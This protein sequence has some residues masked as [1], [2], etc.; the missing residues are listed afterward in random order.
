MNVS[1]SEVKQGSA[2]PENDVTALQSRSGGGTDGMLALP[3]SNPLSKNVSADSEVSTSRNRAHEIGDNLESA[4]DTSDSFAAELTPLVQRGIE[5]AIKTS[6]KSLVMTLG[7]TGA[8]KSTLINFLNDVMQEVCTV[9]GVPS[10]RVAEHQPNAAPL[11]NGKVSM[12]KFFDVRTRIP[13]KIDR[14]EQNEPLHLVDTQGLQDSAGSKYNIVNCITLKEVTK[15]CSS[16]RLLLTLS[17]H[18]ITTDVSK[19]LRMFCSDIMGILGKPHNIATKSLILIVTQ[20]P[21]GVTLS[22]V[23]E[24]LRKFYEERKKEEAR[25]KMESD[26]SDFVDLVLLTLIEDEQAFTFSNQLVAST[27]EGPIGSGSAGLR[28]KIRKVKAEATPSK[29]LDITFPEES[30]DILRKYARTVQDRAFALLEDRDCIQVPAIMKCLKDLHDL[31][32]L[33][34]RCT[35]NTSFIDDIANDVRERLRGLQEM[36]FEVLKSQ[37]EKHT[38]S[39]QH[40]KPEVALSLTDYADFV[41]AID[42]AAS[43]DANTSGKPTLFSLVQ[44]CCGQEIKNIEEAFKIGKGGLAPKACIGITQSIDNIEILEAASKCYIDIDDIDA[45]S[46]LRPY[47]KAVKFILNFEKDLDTRFQDFVTSLSEGKRVDVSEVAVL[48]N[49]RHEL[50]DVV[51]K[52]EELKSER[53][54]TQYSHY[55]D[56]VVKVLETYCTDPAL[57]WLKKYDPLVDEAALSHV[58]E[59]YEVPV[60]H[61]NELAEDDA[62][63][64]QD[65][66]Y[67]PM[68]NTG[69]PAYKGSHSEYAQR[70][71]QKRIRSTGE[72][73][74]PSSPIDSNDGVSIEAGLSKSTGRCDLKRA[75]R[76][77]HDDHPSAPADSRDV[78][79]IN[80]GSSGSSERHDHKRARMATDKDVRLSIMN[81]GNDL[82]VKARFFESAGRRDLKRGRTAAYQDDNAPDLTDGEGSLSIGARFSGFADLSD[83]R[84]ID[85]NQDEVD[86][87]SSS[88]RVLRA[89][90]TTDDCMIHFRTETYDNSP[91]QLLTE[92]HSR[93]TSLFKRLDAIPNKFLTEGA[94]RLIVAVSTIS[95]STELHVGA[96]AKLDDLRR[97][98]EV[99]EELVNNFLGS[100][101]SQYDDAKHMIHRLNHLRSIQ[102]LDDLNED[103]KVREAVK[104][105]EITAGQK[106]DEIAETLEGGKSFASLIEQMELLSRFRDLGKRPKE[107]YNKVSAR[108]TEQIPLLVTEAEAALNKLHTN[109]DSQCELKE[110]TSTW[111]I[112]EDRLSGLHELL[113]RGETSFGDAT[114]FA[115]LEPLRDSLVEEVK[116]LQADIVESLETPIDELENAGDQLK[117]CYQVLCAIFNVK[118]I[119]AMQGVI[120]FPQGTSASTYPRLENLLDTSALPD[121]AVTALQERCNEIDD[122]VTS[123]GTI[124]AIN[125][126]K[127][128]LNVLSKPLDKF[129]GEQLVESLFVPLRSKSNATLHELKRKAAALGDKNLDEGL[130]CIARLISGEPLKVQIK[131][132]K[133]MKR[134]NEINLASY[135]DQVSLLAEVISDLAGYIKRLWDGQEPADI[136]DINIIQC[137]LQVL[138]MLSAPKGLSDQ[139]K[140]SLIDEH[141]VNVVEVSKESQDYQ[142]NEV[143]PAW[144]QFVKTEIQ[145]QNYMRVAEELDLLCTILKGTGYGAIATKTCIFETLV[146]RV[147]VEQHVNADKDDYEDCAPATPA[148]GRGIV[149]T[150][151]GIFGQMVDTKLCKLHDI[152][153]GPLNDQESA[154][155]F[156]KGTKTL[157]NAFQGMIAAADKGKGRSS[158][159]W[160]PELTRLRTTTKDALQ[161]ACCALM[162]HVE[163]LS[164]FENNH[165]IAMALHDVGNFLYEVLKDYSGEDRDDLMK[166][167]PCYSEWKKV[168]GRFEAANKLRND[169]LKGTLEWNKEHDYGAYMK[170]VKEERDKVI[171]DFVAVEGLLKEHAVPVAEL[172]LAREHLEHLPEEVHDAIKSRS[173]RSPED[174]L[175][176]M[177]DKVFEEFKDA[178]K[179]FCHKL[180]SNPKEAAVIAEKLILLSSYTGIR[181][182]D[183]VLQTVEVLRD[184]MTIS[185]DHIKGLSQQLGEVAALQQSGA[186]LDSL[187]NV[188]KWTRTLMSSQGVVESS[189]K[190]VEALK[191]DDLSQADL[192]I[193][194]GKREQANAE[195]SALVA[196]HDEQ[197]KKIAE[198]KNTRDELKAAVS[199][200][201]G[202]GKE[203]EDCVAECARVHSRAEEDSKKYE[204]DCI[205]KGGKMT[206]ARSRLNLLENKKKATATA[207]SE[208]KEA[209][210]ALAQ[211]QQKVGSP[212][213]LEKITAQ[214]K[215]AK[216][217]L[218]KCATAVAESKKVAA[219]YRKDPA[220]KLH[221]ATVVLRSGET[222]A[223]QEAVARYVRAI[224]SEL[225]VL[226]ESKRDR[227]LELLGRIFAEDTLADL[228]ELSNCVDSTDLRVTVSKSLEMASKKLDEVQRAFRDALSI[229]DFDSVRSCLVTLEALRTIKQPPIVDSCKQQ[230]DEYIKKCRN[231]A[232]LRLDSFKVGDE[233]PRDTSEAVAERLAIMSQ[234]AQC[235]GGTAKIV[236]DAINAVLD[237]ALDV[238]KKPGSHKRPTLKEL[239]ACL[240]S[241]AN[242]AGRL[243]AEHNMFIGMRNVGWNEKTGEFGA[244][245]AVEECMGSCGELADDVDKDS[246][247]KVIEETMKKHAK[248]VEDNLTRPITAS[249]SLPDRLRKLAEKAKAKVPQLEKPRKNTSV[250][251]W[252]AAMWRQI[253]HGQGGNEKSSREEWIKKV[254]K[255]LPEIVAMIF[256]VWTIEK[257]ATAWELCGKDEDA[258]LAPKASQLLGIFRLF[259]LGSKVSGCMDSHLAQ[260]RTGEGKSVTLGVLATINA[261]LGYDV[262]VVCYSQ[263]LSRRDYDG[264]KDIFEIFNTSAQ[265]KYCTLEELI[266]R[267][268]DP[269]RHRR[270]FATAACKRGTPPVLV[271]NADLAHRRPRLLQI[272]EFDQVISPKVYGQDYRYGT[273]IS[274]TRVAELMRHIYAENLGPGNWGE[275]KAS[276]VYKQLEVE[277]EPRVLIGAARNMLQCR[278]A[279]DSHTR[280]SPTGYIVQNGKIG[281]V[282]HDGISF[283]IR[284]GYNTAFSYLREAAAGEVAPETA[285]AELFIP[286]QCGEFSYADILCGQYLRIFGVS[287]TLPARED[288]RKIVEA[289]LGIIRRTLVP[290]IF[291]K[292][293]LTFRDEAD[294][295]VEED[296]SNWRLQIPKHT[297]A[298]M[299]S[300]GGYRAVIVVFTSTSS[301]HAFQDSSPGRD[302]E[303]QS[304]VRVQSITEETSRAERTRRIL[305]ASTQGTITYITRALGRG[306]DFLCRDEKVLDNGGVHVLQLFWSIDSAERIQIQGRTARQGQVG[307]YSLLLC[308][309]HLQRLGFEP[310]DIAAWKGAGSVFRGLEN[311]STVLCAE[312]NAPRVLAAEQSKKRQVETDEAYMNAAR[313]NDKFIEFLASRNPAPARLGAPKIILGLD[314]TSS[315][316]KVI[317]QTKATIGEMLG[318]TEKVLAKAGVTGADFQIQIAVYR[319]Y[320]A[321]LPNELLQL[322]S[323]EMSPAPLVAFLDSVDASY[324]WGKEAVEVALAHA[325]A[326][327]ASAVIIIGDAD[328]QTSDDVLFKRGQ[329]SSSAWNQDVRFKDPTDFETQAR[330]LRD[331]DCRVST[332][333]VAKHVGQ[334]SPQGFRRISNMTGGEVGVLN[335]HA[336]G[337]G[338]DDLTNVVCMQ[339]LACLDGSGSANLQA[340]YQR[341]F[342]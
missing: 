212:A 91:G 262:D 289:K 308:S 101:W 104:S 102:W 32:N 327:E 117:Q 81:C 69:D 95:C 43:S 164:N 131:M 99:A 13:L 122:L 231:R 119:A 170:Q 77:S 180:V 232:Q 298:A 337:G 204:R 51:S 209:K 154:R 266:E 63:G 113:E 218:E 27:M 66:A 246:L 80:T 287:G 97:N 67:E 144:I 172:N 70:S 82:S 184:T 314:G 335:I 319:N 259:G 17:W 299:N 55:C 171:N 126:L 140:A 61:G 151:W 188:I 326:E 336:P 92:V 94:T 307:S 197:A 153:E 293:C 202:D 318:R 8:G 303:T 158:K 47:R 87:I 143:L 29:L 237:K 278:G 260:I 59:A 83:I 175:N 249:M 222:S 68:S 14:H 88:V 24:Q 214:L 157:P 219:K 173:E 42:A 221:T 38:Y 224:Y 53:L 107:L 109:L 290:S 252:S 332:L 328:V 118:S 286:L 3:E 243:V 52:S 240:Q 228:R 270:D 6:K 248:L 254:H 230:L 12:T 282:L 223:V 239:F 93:C 301:M 323:W 199:Q 244:D 198:L 100:S 129:L 284:D 211:H 193:L 111:T 317:G 191:S 321:Q 235:I 4:S 166:D 330:L 147:I 31:R 25:E 57:A 281:Y 215:V 261:L 285:A 203:L 161:N 71:D 134:F 292:S 217:E 176:T 306:T 156:L 205:L 124:D 245:Y 105:A 79:S 279:L 177:D 9:D 10:I 72:K 15:H 108:R 264:F 339:I 185:I 28:K 76:S 135:A 265:I 229:K 19:G 121:V 190:I 115:T 16:V 207:L 304:G 213:K 142:V 208:L 305:M 295:H 220:A 189:M 159:F 146:K 149:G 45:A 277:I 62:R 283:G 183:Y 256:A 269:G 84:T 247:R 37:L 268:A 334:T 74:R 167:G 148:S 78:L 165:E 201:A 227:D 276:T 137:G 2:C 155:N 263:D 152:L 138:D 36:K 216:A 89:I 297:M 60:C 169:D 139:V 163:H 182:K 11:G 238:Q 130:A 141:E 33:L 200:A 195:V 313:S 179:S 160:G 86:R 331:L 54:A 23:E 309:P 187:D 150:N 75:R 18:S 73:D 225:D 7:L 34:E 96:S 233:N 20:T 65:P 103:A 133:M 110:I 98:A 280:N 251:H 194:K 120:P 341:M 273:R 310:D 40:I 315:M 329:S 5:K 181:A 316:S 325:V 275:L 300:E 168:N 258:L 253:F 342:C 311:A 296:E 85:I 114:L 186:A 312:M 241:C 125:D 132:T 338:A 324:G 128:T 41:Q 257:S 192:R 174:Y 210:S 302:L 267:L 46:T 294:T 112:V 145:Q 35:S 234:I 106:L 206:T 291:G 39:K 196:N 272:D 1:I 333:F 64:N 288:D 50:Q 255:I 242:Q 322:S 340:T 44:S 274:S 48:L 58:T 320:N 162:P 226:L 90:A 127:C 250:A 271:Q 22:N 123:S 236:N 21:E 116:S 56:E 49:C 136:K 30:L 178:G 26:M